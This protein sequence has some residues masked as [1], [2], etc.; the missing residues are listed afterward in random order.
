M[1]SLREIK[2]EATRQAL[3]DA[4]ARL[5][6]QGGSEVLTVANIAHSAGVSPRT[7]H[8]YFSSA[9]DALLYFSA[10]VLKSFTQQLP[11]IYPDASINEF[12]ESLMLDMLSDKDKDRELHSLPT[13][14]LVREVI[15]NLSLSVEECQKYEFVAQSVLEAFAHREPSL[16]SM[17]LSV[18]L[19]AHAGACAIVIKH[20]TL[21]EQSGMPLGEEEQADLVHRAF[22]RLRMIS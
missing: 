4:A 13:L 16:D 11:E 8:N 3:A 5:V 2:K 21:R 19:N 22:A 1:S 10:E 17:E 9:S 12:F 7:F 20:I 14:F 15:E 6:V 18:V